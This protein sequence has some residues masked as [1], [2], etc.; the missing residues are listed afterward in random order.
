LS[1]QRVP[2]EIIS[3][4]IHNHIHLSPSTNDIISDGPGIFARE[5]GEGYTAQPLK[6]T[7]ALYMESDE[8]SDNDND[9]PPQHI[10]D[11]LRTIHSHYP[12]MNFPQYVEKLKNHGIFYL[13]TAAHFSVRFYEEKVGMS[14][15]SA[16][17]FQ[18]CVSKSHTKVELAK[19]RRKAKGKKKARAHDSDENQEN[20]PSSTSDGSF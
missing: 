13:P 19:E 15:G 16:Y 10:E 7:F 18:S 14:E 9:E 6:R 12:A 11:I 1:L 8:E 17:T 5:R 20:V 3:P 4:V 2:T